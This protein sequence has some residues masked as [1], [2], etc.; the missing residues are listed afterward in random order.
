MRL[1]DEVRRAKAIVAEK[2]GRF[3]DDV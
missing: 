3:G 1:V 2:H